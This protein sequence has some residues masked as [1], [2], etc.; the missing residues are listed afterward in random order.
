M[1]R[2]LLSATV[3]NPSCRAQDRATSPTSPS[4]LFPL[5]PTSP[6]L[7]ARFPPFAT[8]SFPP[9]RPDDRSGLRGAELVCTRTHNQHTP[10]WGSISAPRDPFRSFGPRNDAGRTQP[11]T[12]PTAPPN[13][14]LAQQ[15]SRRRGQSTRT[16]ASEPRP[17]TSSQH[18]PFPDCRDWDGI[19]SEFRLNDESR[20]TP[21]RKRKGAIESAPR[22]YDPRLFDSVCF[23]HD[24]DTPG[25]CGFLHHDPTC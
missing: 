24:L 16:S 13:S 20:Q 14:A 17:Q 18:F 3:R 9:L 5:L 7:S 15:F 25:C 19:A 23:I 1:A 22:C 21:R 2:P 10:P 11:P 8:P 12:I 4:L 6:L